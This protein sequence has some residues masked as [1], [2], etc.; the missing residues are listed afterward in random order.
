M[1]RMNPYQRTADDDRAELLRSGG[2]SPRRCDFR[3]SLCPVADPDPG[4]GPLAA[5]DARCLR[6][7]G[8]SDAINA[9]AA[10][11]KEQGIGG[12][13]VRAACSV[14]VLSIPGGLTIWCLDGRVFQW[15]EA[16][17]QVTESVDEVGAVVL[18][19]AALASADQAAASVPERGDREPPRAPVA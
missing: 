18:R 6:R 10:G 5:E 3:L 11:L 2:A 8:S 14:A 1:T 16:G 19:L 4:A 13:Y 9:L 7:Q 12:G 17:L 15:H